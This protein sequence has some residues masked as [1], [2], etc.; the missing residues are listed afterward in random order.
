LA[1]RDE[2]GIEL[3]PGSQS[4]WDQ[5]EEYETR[6]EKSNKKA[7]D[8]LPDGMCIPLK[9]GDLLAFDANIIHRGHYG[10]DRLSFD[11]LFCKEDSSILQYA[12]KECYPRDFEL[13]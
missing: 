7:S 1:L 9:R 13:K 11:I 10:K 3:I 6:L 5:N 12:K 8:E 4:R 2:L